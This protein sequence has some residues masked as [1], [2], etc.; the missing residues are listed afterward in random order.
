MQS[1]FV[2]LK[3]YMPRSLFGRAVLILVLPIMALQGV[4]AL[5]FIQRHYD[6]VTEQMAGSIARELNFAISAVD[7]APDVAMARRALARMSGPLGFELVLDEGAE[8]EPA[9]RIALFDVTGGVVA[10]TLRQAIRRP[11]AVDL[12]SYDKHVDASIATTKGALSVLVPRRRMNA[13][14][15][16]LLLVWSSATALF[17]TAIALAFLRNQV[18][19][20]RELARA[21]QA[22]GRGRALHFRP[23]GAEEVRRAG[24]AFLEMRAR[25]ER[26]VDQR[27]RMLSGVSHDLRTPLTRMKLALAVADET[28]ETAEIARDIAEMEHMLSAF[29]A[30]ARGEGGEAQAPASPVELAEEVAADARRQGASVQVFA[31]LE[32]PDE[33]LVEMRR[34]GAEA[35][36]RQPGRERRRLC[37]AR[38]AVGAADPALCRVRR[39]GRRPRHTRG[40]ARRGAEALHPAGRGAQPGHLRHRPRAL[41]RARHRPQPRRQP[42]ARRQPPPRR[43]ARHPAGAAVG[44]ASLLR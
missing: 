41:D 1:P 25:I 35:G 8:V 26:H 14:N 31:Q 18:R 10:A 7:E 5:V 13:A 21:A 34:R 36:P 44:F 16:H 3:R 27:T 23:A 9:T 43:P 4:V 17:L 37:R 2:F 19:P 40:Q 32:T 6:S 39:R 38:G 11:L 12:V 24:A 22:F 28:P 42:E 33:P 30:F 15:P 29:L 20:I